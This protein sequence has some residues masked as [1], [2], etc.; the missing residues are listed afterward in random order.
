MSHTEMAPAQA[1]E[2]QGWPGRHAECMV[3]ERAGEELPS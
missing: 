1:R 3:R 2:G